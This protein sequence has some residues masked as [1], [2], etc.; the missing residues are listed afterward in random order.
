MGPESTTYGAV[1]SHI[2]QQVDR[3]E[4]RYS[5]LN[6]SLS[7]M[8]YGDGVE[9]FKEM[10]HIYP[11]ETLDDDELVASKRAVTATEKQKFNLDE[12]YSDVPNIIMVMVDDIGWNDLNLGPLH[13]TMIR[14]NTFLRWMLSSSQVASRLTTTSQRLIAHLR[15]QFLTG[16]YSSFIDMDKAD[17]QMPMSEVTLAQELKTAG[18]YTMHI[19]KWGVGW[20][21]NERF[22]GSWL[23]HEFWVLR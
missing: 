1:R 18:Y 21:T 10:G 9:L 3:V 16:K 14:G 8:C 7:S 13:S 6:T 17:N 19:G 15:G 12:D 5:Y 4:T 20:D 2:M 22:P 23:R 11:Y